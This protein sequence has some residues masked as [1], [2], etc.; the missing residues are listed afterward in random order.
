MV[1]RYGGNEDIGLIQLVRCFRSVHA[2]VSA[3]FGTLVQSVSLMK[4]QVPRISC[5]PL[6]TQ[7]DLD[8]VVEIVH[9]AVEW[10]VELMLV[11]HC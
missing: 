4:V 8:G 7:K 6:L 1:G 2:W 11:C 5:S 3:L 9:F 10:S